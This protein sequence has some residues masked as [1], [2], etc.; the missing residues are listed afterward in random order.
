MKK[1]VFK[2]PFNYEEEYISFKIKFLYG[3]KHHF[4]NI[5]NNYSISKDYI[6]LDMISFDIL[7][8]KNE[9]SNSRITNNEIKKK[10]NIIEYDLP[11]GFTSFAGEITCLEKLNMKLVL[12]IPS[13]QM[14]YMNNITNSYLID[15]LPKVLCNMITEMASNFY[16][17]VSLHKFISFNLPNDIIKII[18]AYNDDHQCS[19]VKIYD[20][21]C[22]NNEVMVREL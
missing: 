13:E 19:F 14:K 20:N 21:I 1:L 5:I 15:Y 2:Y 18:N 22:L 16:T 3:E 17:D 9:I 8:V 11:H 10:K 12:N 6:I 7:Y 4:Y